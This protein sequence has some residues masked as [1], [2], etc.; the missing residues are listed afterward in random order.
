MRDYVA[1]ARREGYASFF[2]QRDEENAAAYLRKPKT[3]FYANTHTSADWQR[4][5]A[6]RHVCEQLER[7]CTF[8][9]YPYH[10][11][12]LELFAITGLWNA[13]EEWKRELV[14]TLARDSQTD[15]RRLVLWDFSGY[16]RYACERVPAM[17]DRTSKMQWY[18]EAGHFKRELG[19]RM[20]SRIGGDGDPEFGVRLDA[21]TIESD[22]SSVRRGHE[23][24]RSDDGADVSELAKIVSARK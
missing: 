8:I 24:Y 9:I 13:F 2:R 4:L 1:M 11:H 14:R 15:Q 5:H 17:G 19:D 18:W 21:S 20:I 7:G 3:V 12:V 16:H 23:R 10:A 6:I 22:L